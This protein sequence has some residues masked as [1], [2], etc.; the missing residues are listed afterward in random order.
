MGTFSST[1]LWTPLVFV[2]TL[3]M[4]HPVYPP[5]V[6]EPGQPK[7]PWPILSA[8]DALSNLHAKFWG[9]DIHEDEVKWLLT[10]PEGQLMDVDGSEVGPGCFLLD[11]QGAIVTRSKLW[12]R[13]DYLRIYDEC[14]S[15][16]DEPDAETPRSV[17][18]TGQPGVGECISS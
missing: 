2:N 3:S 12:V 13:K 6:F 7:A 8:S 17:V 4:A 5:H 14:K 15:Y 1:S 10:Q 18:I 16:Y 9:V 11:L